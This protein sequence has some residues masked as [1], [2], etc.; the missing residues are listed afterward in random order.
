VLASGCLAGCGA[1]E[2]DDGCLHQVCDITDPACIVRIAEVVACQRDSEVLEPEVRFATIA[3]VSEA[4]Q[5]DAPENLEVARRYYAG[6]ALVGLMPSDYA[7][8][9]AA[10]D[11]LENVAAFY[12]PEFEEIVIIED[13]LSDTERAYLV[14][15]HE[16]IHAY[17][18]EAYDLD[19][20]WDEHATT[21]DR[22]LGLRA[23][24]EGEA[25]LYT[26]LARVEL[27]GVDPNRVD[28]KRTYESF[29][30]DMLR[31]AKFTETPSL[32][33]RSLFPYAWGGLLMAEAWESGGAAKLSGLVREPP[34]SV[35]RVM[36]GYRTRP[37]IPVNRDVELDPRA[38][39]VLPGH[40]L[41]GG[42]HKSVWLLNAMLQ[43]TARV[44]YAWYD[45]LEHVGA[46]YLS[47]FENDVTGQPVAVWRFVED[48]LALRG[49][50]LGPDLTV[51]SDDD[52][53]TT[54]HAYHE[55]ADWILVATTEGNA[56]ALR[57]SIT[58]W[59]TPEQAYVRAGLGAPLPAPA[60]LLLQRR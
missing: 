16:M 27:D 48:Q 11:S 12:D 6:E 59:E 35:R 49:G 46:D 45:P 32:D 52:D 9:D 51:W 37:P 17:Q 60:P 7:P 47:V 29:Q 26:L 58:E 14:L 15:L 44:G 39:P 54:R 8:E 31:E 24:V 33:V 3:E 20:L 18:D 56:V 41:I 5:G 21:L 22:S 10:T 23:A 2:E 50:L 55:E 34:D 57:E 1:V 4:W 38:V 28:W 13:H 25:E 30:E 40:T 36:A 42:A 53:E 19:L 43:R